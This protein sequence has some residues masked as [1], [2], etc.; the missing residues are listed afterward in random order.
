M[1]LT[2]VRCFCRKVDYLNVAALSNMSNL[3]LELVD[4]II[5]F[6]QFTIYDHSKEI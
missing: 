6:L 2:F 3:A 5:I 1:F 4:W